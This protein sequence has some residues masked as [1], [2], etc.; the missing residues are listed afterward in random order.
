MATCCARLSKVYM[1]ITNTLFAC[2]GLAFI[3]FG[4][5]GFKSGFY[6][7]SLFPADIFRWLAILGAI[8]C[9]AAIFGAIGAFIKKS[10]IIY[11]YMIIIIAALVLQVIIG[12]KLYQAAA[13]APAYM[14]KLWT[15]SSMSQRASLENEFHCCGYQTSIDNYAPTDQ[16][17]PTK[18]AMTP[19]PICADLLIGYAKT[20]F[21]K[22]YLVVFA[23]LALEILAMSNAI[24]LIC[25]SFGADEE[26]ER[27]KRRKSGIRLDDMSVETPTTLVGS[28]Y[29]ITDEQKKY[30]AGS[31]GA[32]SYNAYSADTMH[33]PARSNGYD[34]YGHQD[35]NA[36][37]AE[38]YGYPQYNSQ[39]RGN[40]Y[41]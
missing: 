33:S 17:Q 41:Y 24:T 36:Y 39:S 25:T 40:A 4:L 23:A 20:T 27:R 15:S 10:F 21:N 13:N 38:H 2:L 22:A 30:Y 31:P 3:A 1:I 26:S 8:I 11:I 32:G 16:C 29:T 19:L 34:A 28:A 9:V 6:G 18:S 5:I 14:S 35:A 12:I 7:S 37:H